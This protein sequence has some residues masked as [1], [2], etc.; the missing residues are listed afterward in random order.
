MIGSI[1]SE[2]LD[3]VAEIQ[4]LVIPLL[5]EIKRATS[6]PREMERLRTGIQRADAQLKS[7]ESGGKRIQELL[8]TSS[9]ALK[10]RLEKILIEFSQA[11]DGLSTDRKI[12]VERFEHRQAQEVSIGE[13]VQQ[14]LQ[15]LVV[16][17]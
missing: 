13:F 3:L 14:I 17:G 4:D 8:S 12:L 6:R 2:K 16:C 9:G 11:I 1:A 15:L 10:V 7:L 5:N